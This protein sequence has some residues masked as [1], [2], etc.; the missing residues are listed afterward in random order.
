M[1]IKEKGTFLFGAF[2][3]KTKC[4]LVFHRWEYI[5]TDLAKFRYCKHCYRR[6]TL[7]A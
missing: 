2:L 7:K 6:Q 4:L 5:R 3:F 1:G